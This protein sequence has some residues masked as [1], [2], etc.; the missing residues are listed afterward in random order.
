MNIEDRTKKFTNAEF[1]ALPRYY[2]RDVKD[3]ANIFMFVAATQELL[4][5]DDDYSRIDDYQ[6]EGRVLLEQARIEFGF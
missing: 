4:L 5:T 1:K 3:L 2:N 6:E